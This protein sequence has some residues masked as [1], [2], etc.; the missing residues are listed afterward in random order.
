MVKYLVTYPCRVRDMDGVDGAYMVFRS[1]GGSGYLG[2]GGVDLQNPNLT[3][4]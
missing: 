4:I 1:G 2:Q 3:Q